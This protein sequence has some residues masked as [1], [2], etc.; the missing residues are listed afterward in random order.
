MQCRRAEHADTS[1][2]KCG[3]FSRRLILYQSTTFL[4]NYHEFYEQDR[5]RPTKC[6]SES[7]QP[8]S[9]FR[10]QTLFVLNFGLSGSHRSILCYSLVSEDSEELD[11]TFSFDTEVMASTGY[12]KNFASLV[13]DNFRVPPKASESALTT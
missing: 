12:R 4:T 2:M 8:R 3:L 6:G 10:S 7:G 1:N 5:A 13:K 9:I 11:L